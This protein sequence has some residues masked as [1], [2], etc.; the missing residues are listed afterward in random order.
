MQI[1]SETNSIF[2][3]RIESLE[4]LW[5]L[6]EFIAPEDLILASTQRKVKISEDKN[7]QITKIIY[8]E[9]LVK[10]TIF[11][12]D[13]LRISGEIQN[14]TQFTSIGQS[15]TLNFNINDKIKIKKENILKYERKILEN[16]IKSKKTKNLLIIL[17]KDQLIT[18]E[19]TNFNYSVIFDKKGL[20][21]KKQ[22]NENINEEEE[23]FK[24]IK[25]Y[26]ERDYSNIIFSGPGPYKNKLEKYTKERKKIKIQIFPS[27]DVNSNS[28][29]KIINDLSK[30]NILIENQLAKEKEI[31]EKLLKNI[32]LNKKA[33]Y[34]ENNTSEA[35]KNGSVEILLITNKYIKTKREQGEN[36]KLNDNIKQVEQLNGKLIILN[37][38][39]ET[40]KILDG[41]SGIAGI[42]RY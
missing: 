25:P 14:E 41:L 22:N 39:Y 33:I 42:L 8:I 5:I 10:K 37:S 26:L 7:K 1:L 16:A 24:L 32:S 12:N 13:I 36:N 17:D 27:T 29:N 23:K 9:L 3:L 30:T 35:I 6:T 20:G 28:I 19:F 34:G 2:E 15:H 21:N 38:K 18:S 40:G 4:D 31:I 11:E